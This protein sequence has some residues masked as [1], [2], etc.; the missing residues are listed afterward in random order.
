MSWLYNRNRIMR[1][2]SEMQL[3]MQMQILL[4]DD[5]VTT[6]GIGGST[7]EEITFPNTLSFTTLT[8]T[9]TLTKQSYAPSTQFFNF[10]HRR[11]ISIDPT[12]ATSVAQIP[13]IHLLEVYNVT[14]NIYLLDFSQ[15]GLFWNN[16]VTDTAASPSSINKLGSTYSAN[17]GNQTWASFYYGT[18]LSSNNSV[19]S[20]PGDIIRV[21]AK[22]Y[23][24]GNYGVN[25][26]FGQTIAEIYFLEDASNSYSTPTYPTIVDSQGNPI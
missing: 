4:N 17:G 10:Y 23:I 2:R 5:M 19:V 12:L 18:K 6:T 11:A 8:T 13:N 3:Q 25:V 15:S 7:E 1:Q 24:S 21:R 20:S 9:S 22:E 26:V 14:Q 16:S